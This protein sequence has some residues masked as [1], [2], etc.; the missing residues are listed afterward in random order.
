LSKNNYIEN[1]RSTEL[2]TNSFD[3]VGV[4]CGVGVVL[5]GEGEALVGSN[6]DDVERLV[7]VVDKRLGFSDNDN[8]FVKDD[9]EVERV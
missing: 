2:Y 5:D 9:D 4:N 1:I 3:V 6:F 8:C 7:L